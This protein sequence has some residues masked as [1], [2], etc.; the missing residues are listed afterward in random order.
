MNKQPENDAL[1]KSLEEAKA[2]KAPARKE[3]RQPPKR[4]PP[5][6]LRPDR[7]PP[8]PPAPK[9]EPPAPPVPKRELIRLKRQAVSSKLC[10]RAKGCAKASAARHVGRSGA[11][12]S[13]CSQRFSWT[14]SSSSS[15]QTKQYCLSGR[16]R[17]PTS[18]SSRLQ[19]G[20]WK[21]VEM[22]AV[23]PSDTRGERKSR[24]HGASKVSARRCRNVPQ[25]CCA[26]TATDCKPCAR[27]WLIARLATTSAPWRR[28]ADYPLGPDTP[29]N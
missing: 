21:W 17:C 4:E 7:E 1:K 19:G 16:V 8:E 18:K 24:K 9:K 29:D 26:C 6:L 15:W 27:W 22:L 2:S 5:E 20:Q 12:R 23:M 13:S 25:L 11:G 28:D 10:A 14:I 3:A